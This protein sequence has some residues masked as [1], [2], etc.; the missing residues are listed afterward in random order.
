MIRLADYLT[1]ISHVVLYH[2]VMG[3]SFS[4][5]ADSLSRHRDRYRAPERNFGLTES[6][7]IGVYIEASARVC[8][9]APHELDHLYHHLT[10]PGGGGGVS[11][12]VELSEPTPSAIP[13]LRAPT[14]DP[15]RSVVAVTDF[16]H[17]VEFQHSLDKRT[18]YL[19]PH[20]VWWSYTW[21]YSCDTTE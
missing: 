18:P 16:G 20:D 6:S 5:Q 11:L 19:P 17:G 21:S 8:A 3:Q 4:P 1:P 12:S 2:K 10:P 13:L 7:P 15:R 14:F 9:V